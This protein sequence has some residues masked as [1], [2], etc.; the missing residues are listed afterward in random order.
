M[1]METIESVKEQ[2][3]TV[4]NRVLTTIDAFRPKILFKEPLANMLPGQAISGRVGGEVLLERIQNRIM[5]L[6]QGVGLG[7]TVET[8]VQPME[9]KSLIITEKKGKKGIH[10]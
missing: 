4:K 1:N 8:S 2:L 9:T 7:R 5:E 3:K 6:R 10:Y